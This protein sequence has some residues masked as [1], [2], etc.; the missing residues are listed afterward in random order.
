MYYCIH[1]NEE[2]WSW[3][4]TR[5]GSTGTR[6][7]SKISNIHC[8]LIVHNI[9]CPLIL[10]NIYCPLIVHNIYCPLI[11][12]NTYCHLILKNIY[13]TLI[14]YFI[15]CP[16]NLQN[17]YCPLIVY[18]INCSLIVHNIN[19][20]FPIYNSRMLS[21]SSLCSQGLRPRA[22]FQSLQWPTWFPLS[23]W[24][25]FHSSVRESESVHSVNILYPLVF[26]IVDFSRT[27]CV[28]VFP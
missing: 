15:Y 26:S 13:C 22:P 5:I 28:S 27:D 6:D 12:Q 19:L 24:L 11:V 8:L 4:R 14:V 9:Y 7:M 1:L 2:L 23:C 18:N 25:V 3:K 17:I 16:L 20:S 21:S 10:H